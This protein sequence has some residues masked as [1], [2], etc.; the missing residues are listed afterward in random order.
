MSDKITPAKPPVS[1]KEIR[2]LASELSKK[3]TPSSVEGWHFRNLV[4]ATPEAWTSAIVMMECQRQSLVD[5]ISTGPSKVMV[6]C[7]L[8]VLKKQLNYET[9]PA[10]ERPL[11]DLILMAH[12]RVVDAEARYNA[13]I[14]NQS[15]TP[16]V[17]EYWSHVLSSAHTRYLKAI[18]S[19]A[20][21]QRLT[22]NTPTLQINIAND[23]SKQVNV[24]GE[25][26]P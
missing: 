8:D 10:I 19:L 5:K 7:E 22:R 20:R 15:V 13:S 24:Q 4:A 11:I 2:A 12:L 26:K 18:E 25:V 9:A 1:L 6:L 21:V 16:S 3:K 23:G 14:V 17:G